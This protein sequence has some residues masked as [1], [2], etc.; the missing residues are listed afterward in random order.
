MFSAAKIVA[1]VILAA[2]GLM[3]PAQST[4]PPSWIYSTYL[5]G[6]GSGAITAAVRDPAG[7]VYVTGTTTSPDF[8]TT[9]GVYESA[10]PGPT[11]DNVVFVSKF[12][13]TGSLVW[14]TFLGPG[15]YQFGIASGIQVDSNENVYVAGI[16]QGPG[17]PST[18]G[19]PKGCVFVTKLNSTAS[20]MVYSVT[21]GPNSIESSPKLV[22]DRLAAAFVTGSGPAGDCC[23]GN[24]GIIG[25]LGGV[26]DFWVAK[27][28]PA[29]TAVPWSVQI[30]GSG[31]D[32]AN[33]LAIDSEN[34]LYIT[35]FTESPDFPRTAGA[36]NQPG[37]AWT[38]VVKL[39]P[40]RP[41]SSSLV[42]SALAGNPGHSPNSFISGES[43]AVDQSGNA[44][45]GNWTYN[46]GLF[47]SP[48]AFQTEAPTVPNAYV[49]ELN[50]P[51]SLMLNGTY[52]GG[53]NLDFV[54]QVSVDGDGN[55]Y[56]AGST[57]SWDFPT[58]AYGNPTPLDSVN[59]AFYVKL[60]PQFAAVSS[61]V[62]GATGEPE[63]YD[64][65]AA[66]P[67]GSGGLWV[68]GDAGSQF[69]TTPDA[70][71][72]AY[73]GN[74]DGYLLHTDFAGLCPS[75]EERVQICTI[76]ADNTL[77]E[78]IH[79]TSQ[80]G[81]VEAATNIALS[82]DGLSA[83]S[84][85]AAQFDTWLPVAPGNHLATV[86]VKDA[87][88]SQTEDQQQFSVVPST[89]CPLNPVNP[90]LTL[91]SPLNAA[92]IKG[93]LTIRVQA[94]DAVPP[95]V[96]QLYVDGNLQT[97]LK[98][99]NGSYTYTLRLTPGIHTVAVQG[100]DSGSRFLA[101]SAVARVIQ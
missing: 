74:D 4:P 71:Q 7:N 68:A 97:I 88:G 29:G 31:E 89:A 15:S 100:T 20:Q 85:N 77:S 84:L 9:A 41:P 6:S 99:Q 96:L 78:R 1:A 95:T 22:L 35:G 18:A 10:Y 33:G 11:G 47:T 34:K 90:S 24:T 40:S 70:Y 8:P 44:Y 86:V 52:L 37:G 57:A 49:F 98:N 66:A 79:F 50:R 64:G 53:G 60:N 65:F 19:S 42:Y 69:A 67:D 73:Q 30:G 80:D 82:I 16:F 87:N 76:S 2:C 61:V 81:N 21:L 48:W 17:F 72:P 55:T 83:Y 51:G 54:G 25:P 23:N 38:P 12:S 63:N 101:T 3:C 26:D 75:A 46:I 94:N 43:I 36:L 28:N 39:D 32:E 59:Q 56:V 5:G 91:C 45:V 93:P 13:A 92:V 58:T 62:F 27:I 14:S